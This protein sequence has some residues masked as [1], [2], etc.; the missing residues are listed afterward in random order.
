MLCV[1]AGDLYARLPAGPL[2]VAAAADVAA[3]VTLDMLALSNAST[4]TSNAGSAVPGQGSVSS[5]FSTQLV[6]CLLF[7]CS[8]LP[9]PLN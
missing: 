2:E 3:A 9:A 4:A 7:V 6:P 8:T 5:C 1:S